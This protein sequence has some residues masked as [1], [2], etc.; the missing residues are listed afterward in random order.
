MGRYEMG[1]PG[2]E[3]GDSPVLG[4]GSEYRNITGTP[5]CVANVMPWNYIDWDI[6]KEN[7][8]SMYNGEVQSA[9]V[10]SYARTTMINWIMDTGTKT[11]EELKAPHDYGNYSAGAE[12]MDYSFIGNYAISYSGEKEEMGRVSNYT[13]IM[14]LSDYGIGY[15]LI[16]TGA[17]TQPEKRNQVNN[18]YD[19]AGNVAEWSTEQRK[20]GTGH[21][22]S[23]GDFTT[24]SFANPV[25]DNNNSIYRA[26][27]EGDMVTSS[28]P[29]LYK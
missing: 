13:N 28:R 4:I 22:K 9:M 3:S 29:I 6:A 11:L 10:N 15:I 19:L 1:M 20:D 24:Y 27:T 17:N 16:P 8:E 26:G 2:Q 25:I 14:E 7:L 18:V 21:R 5:V 23:G 12:D